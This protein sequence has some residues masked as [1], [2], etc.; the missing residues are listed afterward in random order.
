METVSGNIF[1]HA[2]RESAEKKLIGL[3]IFGKIIN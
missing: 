2:E 1:K 3:K